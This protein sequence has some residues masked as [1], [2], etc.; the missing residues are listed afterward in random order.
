MKRRTTLLVVTFAMAVLAAVAV[1]QQTATTPLR[2]IRVQDIALTGLSIAALNRRI[3]GAVK[4][5][6]AR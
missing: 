5:L 6:Q 4:G 2:M 1:G 3:V